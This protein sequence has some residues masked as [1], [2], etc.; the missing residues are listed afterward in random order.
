MNMGVLKYFDF[1]KD[2]KVRKKGLIGAFAIAASGLVGNALYQTYTPESWQNNI[3][4]RVGKGVRTTVNNFLPEFMEIG[5]GA[6]EGDGKIVSAIDPNI[7]IMET[8]LVSVYN[9][10]NPFVMQWMSALGKHNFL[11]QNDQNAE[12]FRDWCRQLDDL[13]GKS[14]EE[15]AIGVD[16][17]V[18]N[19]IT[20]THDAPNYGALEFFASP[21]ETI[22]K[23][24]GDCD[25]YAILKYFALRYLDV[26]AERLFISVVGSEST[27]PNHATLLVDIRGDNI[28]KMV[29][30]GVTGNAPSRDFV[31]INNESFIGGRGPG[32]ATEVNENNYS[33]HYLLNE[34]GIWVNADKLDEEVQFRPTESQSIIRLNQTP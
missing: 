11:M 8:E 17:Y 24:R 33:L 3:E 27:D 26:P 28:L 34:N 1:L 9:P 30:R 10:A 7:D 25:D 13:R 2:K 22:D 16:Q 6:Y 21:L 15:K 20:Y 4:D 14:I 12:L 31:V 32:E 18:D 23:K 5:S 29:W 19:F